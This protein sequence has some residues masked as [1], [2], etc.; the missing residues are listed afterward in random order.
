MDEQ[1]LVRRKVLTTRPVAVQYSLTDFGR[2]ALCILE[3][4][5][6][7]TEENQL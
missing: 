7:W 2:S 3:Q 4:L 1:G 6:D 5:K